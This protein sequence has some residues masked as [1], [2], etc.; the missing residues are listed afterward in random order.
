MA[1]Y[2]LTTTGFVLKPLEVIKAELE[3][4]AKNTWGASIDVSAQSVFGQLIGNQAGEFNDLW[5]L[6]QAVDS[7]FD[8]DKATGNQLDALCALTGTIRDGATKSTIVALCTG[9]NATVLNTGRGA[10]V[11]S[12]GVKFTSTG[13]ATLATA[14][15]WA[16]NTV[17]AKGDVRSNDSGKLYVCTVA[18]TSAGAGGPTGTGTAITDN[19]ATWRYVDTA[20]AYAYVNFQASETGPKIATA[21]TLTTIDTPVAGWNK[22]TNTAD[23]TLGTDKE[24]DTSLRTRREEELRGSGNAA[25][26]A[27]R[28]AVLAVENVVSVT[29][30]E[31]D[32]L[33][34]DVDGIPGKAVECLVLTNPPAS[35]TTIDDAIRAAIFKSKAAGIEAHGTVSGTVTD[36]QGIS[37][38]IKFTRPTNKDINI[39]CNLTVDASLYP[40]DGNA[41]VKT[42]LV[43]F[44]D[45]T[46]K[47]GKNVVASALE[48]VSHSTV[49]GILDAE[50]LI[51]LN[52]TGPTVRTTIAIGL[53]EIANLDTTNTTVNST[54]GTP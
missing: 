18:G 13:A 33:I 47:T 16:I 34:T 22:V 4:K 8:P 45:S 15:A 9:T 23:A 38:T 25:L 37:H 31:N 40:T 39:I 32:T 7:A 2:G 29:V 14:L 1:T 5:L 44:G 12:T 21:Y 53:R 52:P 46:Y 43:A 28:T 54:P 41:K 27:I 35:N 6:L 20:G 17:Y 51:A 36:S 11:A 10:S 42:A 3:T 49:S 19:T 50:C 48:A 26:E 30:F 24:T